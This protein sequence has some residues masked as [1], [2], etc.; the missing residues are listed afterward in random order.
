MLMKAVQNCYALSV[1]IVIVAVA[2]FAYGLFIILSN[3]GCE[4]CVSAATSLLLMPLTFVASMAGLVVALVG[5]GETRSMIGGLSVEEQKR[6]KYMN[7][8]RLIAGFVPLFLA[9]VE[10]AILFTVL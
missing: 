1:G 8:V 2:L 5:R 3:Q 9:V 10:F 7:R 4:V 6:L